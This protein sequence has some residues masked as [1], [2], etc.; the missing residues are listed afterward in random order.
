[1]PAAAMSAPSPET[2]TVTIGVWP[3]SI[4]PRCSPDAEKKNTR[5]LAPPAMISPSRLTATELS[6]V[7]SVMTVG[8]PPSPRDQVIA[9]SG[10][11]MSGRRARRDRKMLGD[12]S[13]R[14][15]AP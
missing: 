15:Q 10:P 8:A 2:A 13:P 6:G 1:M 3:L 12:S 14:P 11:V 5:P 7:G 9:R 4:S